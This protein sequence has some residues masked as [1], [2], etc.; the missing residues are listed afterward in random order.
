MA[1]K[2]DIEEALKS[3][4]DTTGGYW[5]KNNAEYEATDPSFLSRM[6]R[7]FNPYT[8]PG[9]AMGAAYDA[10][11][12]GSISGI[13]LSM[14]QGLPALGSLKVIGEMG[15]LAKEVA[16]RSISDWSKTAQRATGAAALSAG[17]DAAQADGTEVMAPL[18]QQVD[19]AN[20]RQQWRLPLPSPAEAE[21]GF[22]QAQEFQAWQQK[23]LDLSRQEL[24][25]EMINSLKQMGL[26]YK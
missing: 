24:T 25:P 7:T 6:G 3:F 17:I 19:L 12:Q 26:P 2:S 5:S 15:P 11:N 22:K 14:L 20:Q 21:K 9:S 13:G 23:Q 10:G 16:Y 1:K 18:H 8:G 4:S